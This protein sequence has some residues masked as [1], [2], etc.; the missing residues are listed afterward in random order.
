MDVLA[1]SF[2]TRII[3]LHG[4]TGRKW[5]ESLP[6]LIAS[7]ERRWDI[8]TMETFQPLTYN[9]VA[10]VL[11]ADGTEAVLKL[12]VPG[13]HFIR[14]ETCLRRYAGHAAPKLYRVERQLGAMLLERIRPGA[15]L[16]T[17]SEAAA[18]EAAVSVMRLLHK[19]AAPD[20]LFPTVMDWWNGF[21]RYRAAFTG[22]AGPLPSKLVAE[23]EELYG[24]L[25][26]SMEAP[27]LLHGDL[28]HENILA[29][30]R[31]PW[32][33]IDPQGVLGEPVYEVGAFLRNP[34]PDLLQ[35]PG[36][37]E[38]LEERVDAFSELME[39]DRKRIAGWG[40]S[41]AVLSGIWS[42]EDHGRG[43]EGALEVAA[44]LHRFA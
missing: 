13:D 19:T 39:I 2:V 16:K 7:I 8:Q 43:W 3:E 41:Q 33:A 22:D 26:S 37:K 4:D 35:L 40:F 14:E 20:S 42:L 29:G 12:A 18:I 9:Y 28:H 5:L 31:L 38:I 27:V 30:E 11:K 44:I 6:G 32:I 21:A 15:N 25:A 24:E 17:L 10:P 34:M 23:A 1:N 36:W